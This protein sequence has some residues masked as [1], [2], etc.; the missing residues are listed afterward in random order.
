MGLLHAPSDGLLTARKFFYPCFDFNVLFMPVNPLPR[1]SPLIFVPFL[2]NKSKLCCDKNSATFPVTYFF[3][4]GTQC[5]PCSCG[6]SCLL[7]I[8]SGNFKMVFD[9]HGFL[10]KETRYVHFALAEMLFSSCPTRTTK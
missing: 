7:R 3:L 4:P 10:R 9:F 2:G 8:H 5:L 6:L 1:P